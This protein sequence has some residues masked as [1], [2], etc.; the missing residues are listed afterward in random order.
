[1]P[2]HSLFQ[3]Q[4]AYSTDHGSGDS[5]TCSDAVRVVR[6]LYVSALESGDIDNWKATLLQESDIDA[7]HVEAI[8]QSIQVLIRTCQHC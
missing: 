4:A 2:A 8:V 3:V 7:A 5:S 1:M 6:Q